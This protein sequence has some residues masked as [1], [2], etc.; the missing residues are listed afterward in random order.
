MSLDKMKIV[1]YA[2]D[3]YSGS[4]DQTCTVK[5]NPASYTHNHQVKY[6]NSTAQGSPGTTLKFQGIPPETISFDIY[7]DASGAVDQDVVDVKDQLDEFKSVCFIYNGTIHE[8]NYLILSWG[9]LVFKCKLTSLDISYTLFKPD[10]SPLRAKASV[11]FEEA[12]DSSVIAAEAGEES[13]DL[14]HLV[15]VKEG[16]TLPLICKNAYGDASY[17]MEVAKHNKLV[18]YRNLIPGTELYLPPIK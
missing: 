15:L 4:G 16:D 5:I 17:Y 10:G 8:P 13:P 18:N 12:L 7:F 3:E 6:N 1:A 14:T 2:S 11:K 9:S